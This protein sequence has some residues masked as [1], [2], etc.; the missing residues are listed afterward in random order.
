MFSDCIRPFVR[1]IDRSRNSHKGWSRFSSSL[2]E[3]E[4]EKHFLLLFLCT[5][6]TSNLRRSFAVFFFFFFFFLDLLVQRHFRNE[7]EKR[8]RDLFSQLIVNLEEILHIEKEWTKK[9]SLPRRINW[10]KRRFLE[11]RRSFFVKISTVRCTLTMN[12]SNLLLSSAFHPKFLPSLTSTDRTTT[13]VDR[14]NEIVDFSWK[15]PSS[16]VNIDEWIEIVIEVSIRF[17]SSLSVDL[18]VCSSRSIL[19]FSWLNRIL[20]KDKL[21]IFP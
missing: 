4:K 16:L 14:S 18:L 8:R 17:C 6:C 10:T 15:P 20:P 11:K 7:D 21:L 3:R 9:K 13:P 5:S 2:E 1:P 12:E 19:S